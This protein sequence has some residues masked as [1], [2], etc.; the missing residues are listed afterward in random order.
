M[1]KYYFKKK[2]KNY[3]KITIIGFFVI[4]LLFLYIIFFFLYQNKFIREKK[5]V[6]IQNGYSLIKTSKLLKE[7]SILKYPKLLRYYMQYKKLS[8]KSG[9]Y[10]FYGSINIIDISKR[11]STADYGDVYKKVVIPEGVYNKQLIELL[12]KI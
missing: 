8:P 12:K 10:S 11:I 4:F 1:D 3:I 9:S 2:Y 6:Y 7:E 5:I